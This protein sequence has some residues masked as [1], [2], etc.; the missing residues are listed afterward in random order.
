MMMDQTHAALHS[1]TEAFALRAGVNEL[2]FLTRDPHQVDNNNKNKNVNSSFHGSG[3]PGSIRDLVHAVSTFGVQR[4]KRMVRQRRATTF[5]FQLSFASPSSHVR[6]SPPA[7]VTDPAKLRFLFQKELKNSDVSS[8]R[9]VVLPKKAAEAHLPPLDFKEGIPISMDDMDGLHVWSFKY[10]FWPN[11][12]SRMYVLENTGEFVSTHGLQLGD[13]IMVYQDSANQNY[14]IQAKKANSDQ[15]DDDDNDEDTV[16]GVEQTMNNAVN[17]LMIY[18]SVPD[19][20]NKW[21][22]FYMPTMDQDHMQD[23]NAGMSFVYDTTAFSNDSLLDFLG[24]SMTNYSRSNGRVQENFGS[25]ENLS[26]DEFY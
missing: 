3:R 21:S 18:D 25:V 2:G 17:E 7:R 10:R 14:V 13:F 23:V 16:Y 22:S 24:G 8:L 19:Q 20:A 5:N 15:D 1:K 11:N 4:K 6:P 26:L 12:N 9:R